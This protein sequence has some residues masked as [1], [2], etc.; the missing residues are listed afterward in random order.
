MLWTV[1]QCNAML[2]VFDTAAVNTQMTR[3][4]YALP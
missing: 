1:Q 2:T 3:Y 4:S